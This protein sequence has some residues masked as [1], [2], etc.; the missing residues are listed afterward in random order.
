[1]SVRRLQR[2]MNEAEVTTISHLPEAGLERVHESDRAQRREP[3]T[4]LH[5]HVRGETRADPVALS[6]WH[7]GHGATLPPSAGPRAT[8]SGTSPQRKTELAVTSRHCT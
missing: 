1:M 4:K 2:V 6:M 3:R 5:G 7:V 8:P